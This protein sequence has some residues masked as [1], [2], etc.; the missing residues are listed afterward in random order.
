MEGGQEEDEEVA[1]KPE[2]QQRHQLPLLQQLFKGRSRWSLVTP[3]WRW[4]TWPLAHKMVSI[5][6]DFQET[7]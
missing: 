1:V 3:P 6:S 4:D 2:Q 7:E 5:D